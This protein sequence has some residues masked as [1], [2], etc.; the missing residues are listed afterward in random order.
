MIWSTLEHGS[1]CYAHASDTCLQK[2]NRFQNTTLQMLG[3]QNQPVDSLA[4][5][6]TVAHAS[7]LYKQCVME[8][9]PDIRVHHGQGIRIHQTQMAIFLQRHPLG[10]D[11][12]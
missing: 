1:I 6:R 10:H 2:L 3:L 5:R 8:E 11:S 12:W 9:G 4:L 7:M